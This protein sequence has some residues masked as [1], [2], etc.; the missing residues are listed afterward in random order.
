MDE[1]KQ[2]TINEALI[3]SV[4][5]AKTSRQK[6]GELVQYLPAV[7]GLKSQLLSRIGIHRAV[8]LIFH[9]PREYELFP[10]PQTAREFRDNQTTRFVATVIELEERTTQSGK[11]ML[12]VLV[13]EET[14]AF[15]RLIW[16]NQPFRKN[17]LRPSTR[18]VATGV[19]KSTVLHWEM[20]Q[21]QVTI[22]SD[23]EV[24]F[25]ER[26]QPVYGLTEGLKQGAMRSIMR[27][28]LPDLIPLVEESLPQQLRERLAV[29]AIEM[30]LRSIH[31][32]ESMEDAEQARR[33]FK[34][35]ELLVL[36][37]AIAW[38]RGQREKGAKAPVCEA[39]GMIHA[40]I[41][42]RLPHEL[43]GD[44]KRCIEQI[45]ADM[46]AERPMNR[47]LQG[48]VG[49]GKTLVAQYAMLLC[50]A[51]GHQAALM[52]PTEVLAQQ[53]AHSLAK[54]LESSR[55]RIGL[56]TGSMPRK[57]RSELL[58]AVAAGNIDLLIGTQALL[59]NDLTFRS[60]GLVVVD[61]QH[62]FGVMQRA[63]LR[64][65]VGQPH[66]LVLS[67]TPIPR[68]I[69]MTAFGDLDVSVIREKPPGRAKVHTYL[70]DVDRLESWWQFVDQQLAKGRQGYVI[71]PRVSD[72]EGEEIAS[73]QGLLHQL[74]TGAFAHRSLG[75]LH[76][77]MDSEAKEQT[78]Q[79]FLHGRIELLIA[80]TVV[81]VGIDVSNATV[82]TIMD[83]DR[84]GLSQLHQLRGRIARGS[85][86]GYVCAIATRGCDAKSNERLRAFEASQD[87]FQLAELDMQLRGPGDLLGT[88]QHGLPPLKIA[89]L[90]K[91]VEL[92]QLARATAR[93]LL[94]RC[95]ALDNPG[96]SKLVR[97]MLARY[98]KS[99]QLSDIG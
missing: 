69:A 49:S 99:M 2:Q 6:L 13:R 25:D 72:V 78:L 87:G 55:V 53:H 64:S 97:K 95:P 5:G 63:R 29:P 84:L 50:V 66:Y 28:S 96:L 10:L 44:Q 4:D 89:D 47:L 15:V 9:F 19:I 59:S 79:D 65:D 11:H 98:G 86:P 30:A 60:L 61:E 85:Q 18:L 48:D 51:H 76:G 22:L 83:A 91:D 40:R 56:L 52:A 54:N 42:N 34:L 62:K 70:G 90:S 23:E 33:R 3:S 14:G 82:M 37:L 41:L 35:Q 36:Q 43:T 39:T 27:Q 45:G 24:V 81:E 38:Q 7:G 31:F 80:T 71:A 74:R 94:A 68:T 12:G 8:D 88:Q 92:V 1:D 26:P 67:A 20:M 93:E 21:P 32:P 57:A 17:D 75:L 73:A 58:T 46:S 77:R 16:F